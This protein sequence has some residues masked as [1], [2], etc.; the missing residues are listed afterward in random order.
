[1]SISILEFSTSPIGSPT[2]PINYMYLRPDIKWRIVYFR[3]MPGSG[4]SW[5]VHPWTIHLMHRFGRRTMIIYGMWT[6]VYGRTEGPSISWTETDDRPWLFPIDGR[7]W[8]AG[9]RQ[10]VHLMDG[11]RRRTIKN[12]IM[13]TEVD[14]WTDGRNSVRRG[15]IGIKIWPWTTFNSFAFKQVFK[16]GM[17]CFS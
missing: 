10:T 17:R 7:R 12:I 13:W 15:L 6:E 1:M 2:W 11:F 9:R 5:T 14:G 8:T 4:T 3:R 16:P